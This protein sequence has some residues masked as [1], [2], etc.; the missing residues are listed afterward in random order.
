MNNISM[1]N[2]AMSKSF[3][4]EFFEPPF[5]HWLCSK[6]SCYPLPPLI[7]R[8]DNFDIMK[9]QNTEWYSAPFYSH[10]GGYKVCLNVDAN[11]YGGGK[12]THVSVFTCLMKGENDDNLKWPFRGTITVTLL[13]QLQPN[14][15]HSNDITFKKSTS[16]FS[17]RVKEGRSDGWGNYKFT[18]YTNLSHNKGKNIV[19]LQNDCLYFSVDIKTD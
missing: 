16:E 10:F 2:M 14:N 5:R 18:P 11:G 17:S 9:K 3:S 6:P 4:G 7:I 19:Y 13:N 1:V 15:H 8:M 12:G